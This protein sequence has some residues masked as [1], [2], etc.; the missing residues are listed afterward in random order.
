MN[1][2]RN[3]CNNDDEQVHDGPAQRI[4]H[5]IEGEVVECLQYAV[6]RWGRHIGIGLV[7]R[8]DI[9]PNLLEPH[10]QHQAEHQKR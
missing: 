3:D 7:G 8:H 4:R 6:S 9:V 1:Q 10:E 5:D 2:R